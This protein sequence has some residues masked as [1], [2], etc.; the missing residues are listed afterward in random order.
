M[1]GLFEETDQ[2]AESTAIIAV[3]SGEKRAEPNRPPQNSPIKLEKECRMQPRLLPAPVDDEGRAGDSPIEG[4]HWYFSSQGNKNFKNHT[5]E[6]VK[7]LKINEG[8]FYPVK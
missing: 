7:L 1:R 3:P 5:N 2:V 6:P 4:F 8:I